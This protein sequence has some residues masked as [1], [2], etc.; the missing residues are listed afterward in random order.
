MRLGH[1][2][3]APMRLVRFSETADD[4]PRLGVV[5]GDEVAD[6]SAADPAL[7]G[8]LPGVLAG[9]GLGAVAAAAERA[10]RLRLADVS[11]HA[12][13]G[14]PPKFLAIGLNYAA[15]VAESG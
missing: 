5:D 3:L 1:L 11:L 13:V 4:Q 6:V 10:P 15:H 14:R 2:R 8:D 7:S 12:P 9:A